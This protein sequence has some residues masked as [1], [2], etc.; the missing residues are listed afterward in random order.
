MY[1]AKAVLQINGFEN[2]SANYS[3]VMPILKIGSFL[4]NDD[5]MKSDQI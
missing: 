2:V 4:D 3:M 5:Q 1:Y